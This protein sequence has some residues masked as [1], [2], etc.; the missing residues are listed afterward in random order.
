MK[1]L[2]PLLL[3]PLLLIGC[4]GTSQND[5]TQGDGKISV[6]ADQLDVK[7]D[8]VCEMNMEKTHI[9]DTMTYKGKLIGFCNPGCKEEF[10]AN[11]EKYAEI[12]EKNQK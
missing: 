12:L 5:Q 8:P 11:P 2:L 1:K 6:T 10:A 9:S 7:I 3:L 4:S